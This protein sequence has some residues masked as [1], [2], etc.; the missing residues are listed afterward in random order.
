MHLGRWCGTPRL[1]Q[2]PCLRG[3]RLGGAPYLTSPSLAVVFGVCPW[4]SDVASLSLSF[5]F[6]KMGI[7]QPLSQ[8]GHKC[9]F[10]CSLRLA[11]KDSH[12]GCSRTDSLPCLMARAWRGWYLPVWPVRVRSDPDLESFLP[13]CI[14]LQNPVN[15]GEWP[16][17]GEWSGRWWTH[18]PVERLQLSE[19][20]WES[21]L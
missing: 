4:A 14:W 2:E 15:S 21:V 8:V 16:G 3:F 10:T 12:P 17:A 7:R 20:V 9:L 1:L 6:C 5:L 11:P 13:S 18:H 19:V